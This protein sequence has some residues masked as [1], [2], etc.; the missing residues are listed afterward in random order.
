MIFE[1]AWSELENRLKTTV[2]RLLHL[3]FA[4]TVFKEDSV[5]DVNDLL[6]GPNRD[7]SGVQVD[8]SDFSTNFGGGTSNEKRA[9]FENTVA[10]G[11]LGPICIGDCIAGED[12]YSRPPLLPMIPTQ[13][14]HFARTDWR[15]AGS[16]HTIVGLETSL[17]VDM[18]AEI[19]LDRM[20]TRKLSNS[21]IITRSTLF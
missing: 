2:F 11:G 8:L 3:K 19:E 10:F 18:V 20:P 12:D 14:L 21:R 1:P 9:A 17:S 4:F 7:G 13:D 15:T 5:S 6:Q 16:I